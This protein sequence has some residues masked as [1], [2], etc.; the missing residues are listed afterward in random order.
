MLLKKYNVK[1]GLRSYSELG[2]VAETD[3]L[4]YKRCVYIAC[5]CLQTSSVIFNETTYITYTYLNGK[6]E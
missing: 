6:L 5:V 2:E 3:S 4:M 1:P